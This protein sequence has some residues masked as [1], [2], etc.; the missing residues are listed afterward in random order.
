MARSCREKRRGKQGKGERKERENETRV[1][2][3]GGI[4]ED[5][6]RARVIDI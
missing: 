6:E 3:G 1:Y 2:V 5:R 4:R